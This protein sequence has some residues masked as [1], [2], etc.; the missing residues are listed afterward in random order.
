MYRHYFGEV[1]EAED[2]VI[3]GNTYNNPELINGKEQP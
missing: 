3:I 1:R 2:C